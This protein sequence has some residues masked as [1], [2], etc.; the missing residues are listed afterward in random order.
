MP[1]S[2]VRGIDDDLAVVVADTI[3]QYVWPVASGLIA[4]QHG[5]HMSSTRIDTEDAGEAAMKVFPGSIDRTRRRIV[6][7]GLLALAGG[8]LMTGPARAQDGKLTPPVR[9]RMEG[10]LPSFGGAT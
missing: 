10:K 8:A 7:S 5:G 3:V 2:A 4:R 9:L 6:G 1:P